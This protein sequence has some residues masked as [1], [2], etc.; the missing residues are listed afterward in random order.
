MQIVAV[1]VFCATTL[2]PLTELVALLYVLIPIRSGYVP[3]AST[4]CC[5][6]SSSCGHGA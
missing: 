3:P 6:P 2:F 5:G 4:R 1:M